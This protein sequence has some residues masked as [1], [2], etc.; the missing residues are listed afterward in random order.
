MREEVAKGR[1]VLVCFQTYLDESGEISR[2]AEA[3]VM[4]GLEDIYEE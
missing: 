3:T 4:G 2:L 1:P